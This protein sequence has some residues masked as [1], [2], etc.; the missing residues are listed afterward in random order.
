LASIESWTPSP[1]SI[2]E[3]VGQLA[4]EARALVREIL[5]LAG[6]ELRVRGSE[7]RGLFLL[8]AGALCALVVGLLAAV[9]AAVAALALVLPLWAAALVVAV[10]VLAVAGVLTGAAVARLRRIA[11]PPEQTLAVL[12]QGAQW[13]RAE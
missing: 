10:A 13:L 3:L 8:L 1:Q 5:D 4:S 6:A 2:G 9:T 11:K 12:K 7:L